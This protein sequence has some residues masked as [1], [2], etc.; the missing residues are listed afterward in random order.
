MTGA[1]GA[2]LAPLLGACHDPME[3]SA[4]Q[5]SLQ[6]S[7]LASERRSPSGALE[8]T[9]PSKEW[10]RIETG[11]NPLE[12]R[13]RASM[14]GQ[15]GHDFSRVRVHSGSSS[16]HLTD[17]LSARALTWGEH[18]LL[19]AEVGDSTPGER[20]QTMRH[21]LTHVVQQRN[22]GGTPWIQRQ[23]RTSTIPPSN[24]T[25]R[26][27][28]ELV[29]TVYG[30]PNDTVAD[31]HYSGSARLDSTGAIT[32]GPP[33]S[34]AKLTVGTVSPVE[35]AQRIADGLVSAQIFRGPRVGVSVGGAAP[36]YA[37]AKTAASPAVLAAHAAFTSYLATTKEPPAAIARYWQWVS[38]HRDQ[39]DFLTKKPEELWAESLREPA[40]K[41]DPEGERIALWL[42]FIKDRQ[43][44][45]ASLKEKALSLHTETLSA[46]IA[47]FDV[48]KDTPEFAAA[49]PAEVYARLSVASLRRQI[50]ADIAS[51]LDS[52]RRHAESSPEALAARG[53][54][55]DEFLA[56]AMV[57]WG[58]TNRNYPYTI[59]LD[60]QGKDILVTGHPAMKGVL[61]DLG[62]ALLSWSSDHF[63]DDNYASVSVDGVLLEL[64]KGGYST[65][66]A[67][68]QTQPLESETIDRNELLP[69]MVASSFGETVAKGL[70]VVAVVGLFVGAEVLTLGQATWILV[71]VAG[72]AGITSYGARREEIE[73]SGYEV[74]VSATLVHSAGDVVGVSQL[75]EG[76]TGERLGTA[77]ALGS[78]G[79]S[80]QLGTGGGTVTTLLI[81]S[82]AYKAGEFVGQGAR[83]GRGSPKTLNEPAPNAR[84]QPTP[85]ELAPE[86]IDLSARQV[87]ELSIVDNV[88]QLPEGVTAPPGSKSV[89]V[90]VTLP[91]GRF[92]WATRAYDPVTGELHSLQINLADIP[93][94]QR[95]VE[96]GPGKR[97]PLSDYLTIRA[98]RLLD[99][100]MGRLKTVRIH[101][102]ENVRTVLQLHLGKP[103][104]AT[105][106]VT[107]H[108]DAVTRAGGQVSGAQ[109]VPGSGQRLML[110]ELLKIWEGETPPPD[111]VARHDALLAEF[112]LTR[113][114]AAMTEVLSGFD[115]VIT[116]GEKPPAGKPPTGV[117]PANPPEERKPHD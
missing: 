74:P 61:D 59:P 40:Q 75:V 72:Y 16:Q 25:V 101:E 89:T 91:D 104:T 80:T 82:R 8:A 103:L 68:A 11:G 79:R 51:K 63:G 76:I 112:G 30:L 54:K 27:G 66:I 87:G 62:G 90:E 52:D 95:V 15:L 38:E 77:A 22:S 111:M 6:P 71:G 117:P 57:L 86:T 2:E 23:P 46:F 53:R 10:V 29:I 114:K 41:P 105:Q 18:I 33:D 70:L 81:G 108:V 47:W 100:A 50:D 55:F 43:S 3:S 109:V 28:D 12:A 97:V 31:R 42:R 39:P 73:R 44:E 99:I 106:T 78:E 110:T 113:A 1:R 98:M 5:T 84:S 115:I 36:V 92:G 96:L 7:G 21:E 32:L 56:K 94:A 85:G 116:L 48:H 88:G 4:Q 45:G 24:A 20:A 35:A 83:A 37:N 64:L 49:D 26:P 34:A 102:V 93:A 69:G 65:R 17:A 19:G 13:E 9:A 58:F 14:E 60:A 107:T 67:A